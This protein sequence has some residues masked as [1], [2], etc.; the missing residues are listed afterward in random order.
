MLSRYSDVVERSSYRDDGLSNGIE[1]RVHRSQYMEIIGSLHAQRDWSDLV[2]PVVRYHGGLGDRFNFVSVTIP[3]CLPERLEIIA[4]ANEYAFLYDDQLERL[5]LK[6]FKEGRDA[7]L[8]VFSEDALAPTTS[9]EGA[10]SRPEKDIQLQIFTRMKA[11]DLDRAVTTMVAWADF[12]NLASRTRMKPFKTLDQYLPS[13]AIDAG[14]LFWFGML[15][16]AQGL[17]IPTFEVETCMRLARPG[18]EAISLVNDV[19]SWPK[20]RVEA[21]EAG[22]DYVFNAVWVVMGERR[23]DEEAALCI[24]REK[25]QTLIEQFEL[26]LEH[27]EDLNLS[28]QSQQYLACVRQSYV[29]N[30]IWSIYCP[31]YQD[32]SV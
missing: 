11:I 2:S 29:G 1:L 13:R 17:T 14:E 28:I 5:D 32:A 4:Y 8:Q 20:E 12:V 26:N 21:D 19:Y 25:I 10:A 6:Q 15:T 24:C 3:D 9:T 18:Y 22:Q 23:C 16:F 27:S 7:I 31:R 30:L